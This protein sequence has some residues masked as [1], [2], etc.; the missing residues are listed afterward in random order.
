MTARKT[1]AKPR[2]PRVR[3]C[4]LCKGTGKVTPPA[5]VTRGLASPVASAVEGQEGLF[6]APDPTAATAD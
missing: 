5:P 2:K 4:P 1:P 6:E 3:P